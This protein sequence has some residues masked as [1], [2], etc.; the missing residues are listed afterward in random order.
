MN[1]TIQLIFPWGGGGN[2]IRWL[3]FLDNKFSNVFPNLK[4]KLDFLVNEVY[5]KRDIHDWLKKEV[6]WRSSGIKWPVMI[7]MNHEGV[8]YNWE[9]DREWQARP[10]IYLRY[11]NIEFLLERYLKFNPGLNGI[12]PENYI[13]YFKQWHTSELLVIKNKNYKNKLIVDADEIFNPVLSK[14]LYLELINFL[15]LDNLYQDASKIHTLWIN[16]N[17]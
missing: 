13:R 14:R 9:N 3:L 8:N 15:N 12:T 4:D 2:H 17:E 5:N 1:D 11:N 6:K 10:C 7:N 16:L